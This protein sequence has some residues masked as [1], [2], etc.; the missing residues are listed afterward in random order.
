[1]IG[2]NFVRG[3]SLLVFFLLFLPGCSR[4]TQGV[5]SNNQIGLKIAWEPILVYTTHTDSAGKTVK[6]AITYELQLVNFYPDMHLALSAVEVRSGGPSGELILKL[7]KDELK[8]CLWNP[9]STNRYSIRPWPMVYMWISLYPESAV[10]DSLYHRVIFVSD[11][12]AEKVVEGGLVPVQNA[13]PAVLGPPVRGGKWWAWHAPSN[14]LDNHH[15]HG[16][17]NINGLLMCHPERSAVD[18]M[19][20]GPDG[21]IF[22]NDGSKNEDFYCYGEELLSVADAT[23]VDARDGLPENTP[24]HAPEPNLETLC[25]N[26][27]TLDMGNGVFALYAHLKTGTL[28][29]SAGQK[30]SR[31]QLL[32]LLGNS[33]NSDCPH[34]HFQ[35]SDNR[36][37]FRA[38]G[39]PFVHGNFVCHGTKYN[40]VGP[41][42]SA[43]SETR[44]REIPF[45]RNVVTFP[46]LPFRVRP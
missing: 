18:W 5:A 38:E 29:V 37:I 23:V 3:F 4:A 36:T 10:P 33:G 27:V 30:V 45:D 31:G 14:L 16:L 11:R 40:P 35:I 8:N 6:K 24:S 25:G 43:T 17:F 20:L 34:L 39:L 22:R 21:S 42:E 32:G 9:Y 1:M 26:S 28:K 2:R 19:K 15:R 46:D 41:W 12:G 13:Q 7:E 44:T